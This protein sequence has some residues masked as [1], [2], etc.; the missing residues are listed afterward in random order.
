MFLLKAGALQCIS[1]FREMKICLLNTG[2]L[3]NR[4]GFIVVSFEIIIL[5]LY[6]AL[7]STKMSLEKIKI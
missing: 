3:L 2:C 5:H 4:G 1:L 7:N 6:G